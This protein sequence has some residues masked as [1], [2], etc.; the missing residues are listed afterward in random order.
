[1]VADLEHA[2]V[3]AFDLETA[4][5]NPCKDSIRLLSLATKDV[6]Y[7]VNCQSVDPAELSP[8]LTGVTVVAHDVEG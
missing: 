5:P 2:D 8:I 4:G 1:V 7:I 3:V 6:I